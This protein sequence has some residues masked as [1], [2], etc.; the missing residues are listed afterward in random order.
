MSKRKNKVNLEETVK[1]DVV[2]KDIDIETSKEVNEVVE[3]TNIDN[4]I[5]NTNTND[6]IDKLDSVNIDN[7]TN[8]IT[9][10]NILADNGTNIED[11]LNKIE[12]ECEFI[13][14]NIVKTLRYYNNQMFEFVPNA[15]VGNGQNYTLYNL[16]INIVNEKK[17]DVFKN[18]FD[19]VNLIFKELSSKG[20]YQPSLLRFLDKWIW[21]V[22]SLTTY[23]NLVTLI[24]MLCDKSTRNKNK[25]KI[26]LDKALDKKTTSFTDQAIENIKKYYTN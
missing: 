23:S 24:C 19:I 5:T 7:E 12:N 18:K 4:E 10:D 25:N 9:V 26:S 15:S 2:N 1:E 13:Y 22:K 8:L 20:F 3:K 17:Y 11:K 21:G 16:L 14:S 6:D